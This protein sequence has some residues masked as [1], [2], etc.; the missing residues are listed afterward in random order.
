LFLLLGVV[1]FQHKSSSSSRLAC[2]SSPSSFVSQPVSLGSSSAISNIISGILLT[3]TRA[4]KIGDEVE[5]GDVSG[6]VVE[7]G[8]LVTRILTDKNY[9]ASI[10]NA[11]V[12]GSTVTNFRQGGSLR[13]EDDQPPIVFVEVAF[14]YDVPWQ[15]AYEMLIEAAKETKDVLPD[16][17]PFVRNIEFAEQGVI[18]EIN[19][20]TDNFRDD[21]II[22]SDLRR[23]IQAKCDERGIELEPLQQF[24][25]VRRNSKPP[26]PMPRSLKQ[27]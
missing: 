27:N 12:L 17:E 2:L 1:T 20:F 11:E 23:N 3:Y 26:S 22:E 25:V 15:I 24:T 18:Y 4:F 16:P 9:Y 5:I 6:T 8:L 10:P 19:V 21:E 14:R 7:K 13:G